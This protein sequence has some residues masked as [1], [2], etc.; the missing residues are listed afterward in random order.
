MRIPKNSR[1]GSLAVAAALLAACGSGPDPEPDPNPGPEPG[2]TSPLPEYIDVKFDE[3]ISGRTRSDTVA[4]NS[5]SFIGSTSISQLPTLPEPFRLTED[6]CSKKP[7]ASFTSCSFT[8]EFAPTGEGSFSH[9]FNVPSDATST[10]T[11]RINGTAVAESTDEPNPPPP[12]VAEIPV[13]GAI[14]QGVAFDGSGSLYISTA[15]G[16]VAKLVEGNLSTFIPAGGGGMSFGKDIRYSQGSFYIQNTLNPGTNL[17]DGV[18]SVLLFASTGGFIREIIRESSASPVD[19]FDGIAVGPQGR[20]FI[21]VS[22]P[23]FN[24]YVGRVD[25]DGSDFRSIVFLG[26]GDVYVP[27]SIAVDSQENLYVGDPNVVSKFDADGNFI[28]TIVAEGGGG[29]RGFEFAS[30][31][32]VD[33]A[34]NLY[35]GN[36]KGVGTSTLAWNILKFNSD[37]VF[38]GE[39]V[40]AG[41]GGLGSD[42][43]D[44]NV[45]AQGAL[46]IVDSSSES[47]DGVAKFTAEGSF[48]QI[49]AKN[50]AASSTTMRSLQDAASAEA[51][52]RYYHAL[53]LKAKALAKESPQPI[54]P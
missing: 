39:F 8:V 19:F 10:V 22:D 47:I 42:P 16:K 31:L 25:A 33:S 40:A 38:E 32:A 53:E 7:V 27:V 54:Q 41:A 46:Y 49:V 11:V 30:H 18:D 29:S 52:Q 44:M 26:D 1:Y 9:S 15:S 23:S 14:A 3:T 12:P 45:D 24:S 50:F 35:I 48:D 28:Q 17:G 13:I 21:I 51:R 20:L 36:L 34:D 2:S 4:L 37:G 43:D 6:G 5:A